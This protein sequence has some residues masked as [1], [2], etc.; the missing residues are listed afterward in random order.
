MRSDAN[1]AGSLRRGAVRVVAILLLLTATP[2]FAADAE[3]YLEHRWYR[4]ELV[5]FE[6][7]GEWP[8]ARPRQLEAMRLP[9]DAFALTLAED[10]TP[11]APWRVGAAPR[12]DDQL[13]LLISNVAPPLWVTGVCAGVS[14]PGTAP[15]GNAYDPC[16]P[17]A[18]LEA[19]FADDPH[20]VW[21]EDRPPKRTATPEELDP[22]GAALEALLDG[23][24]EYEKGL[25][26][27]SYRWR[28]T[29]PGLARLLPRLRDAYRVVVAG[30][31][32]QPVPS[33]DQPQPLLVQAG[34]RDADGRFPVEGWLSI[35]AARFVH[36]EGRLQ[37]RHQSGRIALLTQRRRMANGEDHYL[38]HRAVGILARVERLEEPQALLDLLDAYEALAAQ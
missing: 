36:W 17:E 21:P 34:V 5:L 28:P 32:H 33:R 13:P 2:I 26:A 15:E 6:Q 11:L 9:L 24:R 38:D 31:W 23:F 37:Y 4:I 7:G 25:H 3:D 8:P 12:Y 18:D 29:T 1:T 35:V 10:T 16:L 14:P 30:S 22:E 20:A 27:S 19:Y